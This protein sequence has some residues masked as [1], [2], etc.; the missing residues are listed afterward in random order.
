MI[1]NEKWINSLPRKSINLNANDL[2]NKV[3]ENTVPKKRSFSSIK[4]YSALSIIFISGLFFVSVVKNESRNLQKE[5][6]SIEA[7]INVLKFNL[8]QE[9]L[10]NEIFT[11]PGYISQLAKDHLNIGLVA[12]N[13]SQIN[14]LNK[15]DDIFCLKEKNNTKSVKKIK[16]KVIEQ[17]NAKKTEIKKLQEFYNEPQKIPGEIKL[18]VTKTITQK[19]N[20]LKKLYTTPKD[21]ITFNRVQ[22]WTAVQ[23]AKIFL[24]VPVVPGK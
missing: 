21:V 1:N 6:N 12:Y 23:V 3:W 5:I 8:N 2:D 20:E 7:S 13:Q 17:I 22:R 18:K 19:K 11:S 24:G 9:T 15:D 14:Y 16:L 4:I 10:D